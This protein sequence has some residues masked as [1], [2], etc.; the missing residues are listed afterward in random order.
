MMALERG[1]EN[2]GESVII[3]CL[4]NSNNLEADIASSG[5]LHAGHAGNVC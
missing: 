5:P 2:A 1:R 4:L 3:L